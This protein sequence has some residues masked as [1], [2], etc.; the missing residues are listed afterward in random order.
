MGEAARDRFHKSIPQSAFPF[1]IFNDFQ[2]FLRIRSTFKAGDSFVED[3]A[4]NHKYLPLFSRNQ[5]FRRDMARIIRKTL[6]PTL[7]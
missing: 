4:P 1:G 3:S 2:S 5:S 7:R 6:A